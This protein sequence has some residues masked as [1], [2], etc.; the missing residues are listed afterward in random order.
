MTL[1]TILK[2]LK[3]PF[4]LQAATDIDLR[5]SK[6]AMLLGAVVVILTIALYVHFWDH[7]TPMF[8]GMFGG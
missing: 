6:S 2:P 7:T 4:K 3:E 5:W 1:M 8:A